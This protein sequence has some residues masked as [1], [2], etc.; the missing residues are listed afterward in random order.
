MFA[1]SPTDKDWFDFLKNNEF[2]SFVN[3]WTPTSWNIT[4][5]MEGNKLYF[6]LKS[7]IRKIGGFGEFVEYKNITAEK[8]WNEFGF[9]NGRN[10]KSK[11][12]LSIQNYLDKNSREFRGN[13]I[14]VSSHIIGCIVLKNCEFWDE[15]DFID[16]N[17]SDIKFASQVVKIKYFDCDDLNIL[18]ENTKKENFILINDERENNSQSTK[19]GRKGQEQF[20]STILKVYKNKCCISNCNI[21]ELLD[22]AHIQEYRNVYSNHPMNGILLRADLHRLFD[23]GLIKIDENYICHTS[24]LLNESE[25]SIFNG[26]R[27]NI[28]E[29]LNKRPSLDA[30]NY[31]NKNFRE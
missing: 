3:F 26:I 21:P 4:R 16:L 14:D 7:P 5:L 8:A 25:Y 15:E 19:N 17:N 31:K 2:N 10:S 18:S 29:N 23:N 30:L 1:I 13:I 20:K 12:I 9:R 6:M 11:F 28:P 24:S 22:V 27:I